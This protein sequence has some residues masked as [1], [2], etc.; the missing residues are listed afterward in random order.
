MTLTHDPA[1][2]ES[3]VDSHQHSPAQQEVCRL[4]VGYRYAGIRKETFTNAMAEGQ[5][6]KQQNITLQRLLE[7]QEPSHCQAI[8]N[9]NTQSIEIEGS[10]SSKSNQALHARYVTAQ[11]SSRSLTRAG[12]S[13]SP[14]PADTTKYVLTNSGGIGLLAALRRCKSVNTFTAMNNAASSEKANTK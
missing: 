12:G 2:C 1:A 4:C 11:R 5:G 6:I 7:C 10:Q 13:A 14:S 3:L 9:T 8:A